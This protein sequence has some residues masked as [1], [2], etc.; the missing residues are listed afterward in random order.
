M[1]PVHCEDEKNVIFLC[2]GACFG[3]LVYPCSYRSEL[4]LKIKRD[5]PGM[6]KFDDNFN[7]RR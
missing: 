7:E 5:L 4:K 1:Y 2:V 6:V 3:P